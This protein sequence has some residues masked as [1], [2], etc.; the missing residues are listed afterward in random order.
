[1][2]SLRGIG[3]WIDH[4]V[5]HYNEEARKLNAP[6]LE[7]PDPQ[8]LLEACGPHP[9]DPR[10]IDY[11]RA[12]HE[13]QACLGFAYCRFNCG[14]DEEELGCRDLSDGVWVWPEGLHHYIETHQVPLPEEFLATMAGHDWQVPAEAL[15][16]VSGAE[17]WSL[18]FWKQW[19]TQQLATSGRMP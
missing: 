14:I 16:G 17:G 5:L 4:H 6:L 12:G 11:L 3:Y 10:V 7:L 8:R 18:D 9:V 2:T 15:T 13:L 1:M 19:Y